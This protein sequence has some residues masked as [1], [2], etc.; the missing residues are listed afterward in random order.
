DFANTAVLRC[1]IHI[2]IG[3]HQRVRHPLLDA[4]LDGLQADFQPEVLHECLID[5]AREIGVAPRAY[6]FRQSPFDAAGRIH[7]ILTP[8]LRGWQIFDGEVLS[9]GANIGGRAG[10]EVPPLNF[11]VQ[12]G[13]DHFEH[14]FVDALA[15]A[16]YVVDLSE[17]A[18][19]AC[20]RGAVEVGRLKRP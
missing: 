16:G 1:F 8:R 9:P 14:L 19:Y 6:N 3:Q 5:V 17:I 12:Y 20:G 15:A 7:G 10:A 4:L 11:A 18:D 2:I 13:V